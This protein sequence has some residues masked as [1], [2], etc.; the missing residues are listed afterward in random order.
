MNDSKNP[1]RWILY[2]VFF[3][4]TCDVIFLIY[5]VMANINL[6][7]NPIAPFRLI[8]NSSFLFF[9][10]KRSRCAWYVIFVSTLLSLPAYWALRAQS[11]YFKPI[12]VYNDCLLVII[13]TSFIIFILITYPK[14]IQYLTLVS[15]DQD[16]GNEPLLPKTEINSIKNRIRTAVIYIT[17][18]MVFL[19]AFLLLPRLDI[20]EKRIM[21]ILSRIAFLLFLITI[22]KFIWWLI[23]A[24]IRQFSCRGKS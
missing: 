11:I 4:I 6:E 7:I 1:L 3:A 8:F 23:M 17:T 22:I 24:G 15:G 9:Y 14:Y 5:D 13:W 20:F 12:S 18:I 19:I 2:Y 10:T 21:L 16:T